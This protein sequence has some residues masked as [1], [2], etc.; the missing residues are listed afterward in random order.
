MGVLG[1]RRN[2]Y[3]QSYTIINNKRTFLPLKISTLYLILHN[4]N[5][6]MFLSS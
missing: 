3:T 6:P 5:E 1:V 2:Y 4:V